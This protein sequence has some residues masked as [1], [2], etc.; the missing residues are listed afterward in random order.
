MALNMSR[1]NG[2]VPSL[3]HH[4]S[5]GVIAIDSTKYGNFNTKHRINL[6][7]FFKKTLSKIVN[8]SYSSIKT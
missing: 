3:A 5:V 4:I 1:R 6:I 8:N 7:L 2:P